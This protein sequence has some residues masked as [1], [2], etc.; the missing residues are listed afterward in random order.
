MTSLLDI[1]L[2]EDLGPSLQD[3]TTDLLFANLKNNTFQAHIKSKQAKPIVFCG[4]NLIKTI[5]EKLDKNFEITFYYQDGDWCEP[6]SRLFDIKASADLILKTE[7]IILNFL[8]RL[9]AIATL[10]REFVDAISHTTAK[11]LDTRKTTPGLRNLEKYAVRCGGGINH[12]MGLYDALMIK[13]THVDLLGGMEMALAQLPDTI[14]LQ[15]PVIVEVRNVNELNTVLN[16]GLHKISR[17]LLDNMT[18]TQ[19]KECVRLCHKKISTESSGNINLSN[20]K[21]VAET[22]VDF[23]SIGQLTH[24][25]GC[26]DLSMQCDFTYVE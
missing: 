24:S 13:D 12:R 7:R 20:I 14:V 10:T 26:V 6:G 17:V 2:T 3:L 21:E 23:I 1:A 15:F 9:S 5:L 19:L 4:S 25:A 18:L 22:G 11:I 8:Q 16:K